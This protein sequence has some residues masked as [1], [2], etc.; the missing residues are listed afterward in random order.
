MAAPPLVSQGGQA[1]ASTSP[2][3]TRQLQ[4]YSEIERAEPL[5]LASIPVATVIMWG[6]S[7]KTT[8]SVEISMEWSRM[9]FFCRKATEQLSC[10]GDVISRH[11]T[12]F[13]FLPGWL[14]NPLQ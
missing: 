10:V 1:K 13:P 5:L 8:T 7:Q 4:G 14:R 3:G 9:E 6:A 11:H 12:T 2:K